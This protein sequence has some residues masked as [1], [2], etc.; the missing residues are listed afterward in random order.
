MITEAL[1]INDDGVV[2]FQST[3]P[4]FPCHWGDDSAI[5]LDPHQAHCAWGVHETLTWGS[6]FLRSCLQEPDPSPPAPL[7]AH[8]Q[9][10]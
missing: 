1:G 9:E 3:T 6:R 7:T 4:Y 10:A 5:T 8:T 2:V